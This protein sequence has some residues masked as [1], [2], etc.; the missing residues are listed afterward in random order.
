MRK[1]MMAAAGLALLAGCATGTNGAAT[2]VVAMS[3]AVE[4]A[5]APALASGALSPELAG[6]ARIAV[7]LDMIDAW[8][9]KDW[10]R[11]IDLFAEDGSLH[12]MMIA[13]IVGRD[14]V[15]SR[16]NYMAEGLEQITLTPVNLGIVNDVVV[17]ERV[18]SFTY[19][20]KK[21]SVPVVGIIVVEDGKV[22]EWRE[23]Y[24]RAELLA[25]MGIG[26]DFDA[27][28]R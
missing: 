7:V 4:R 25:A 27:E 24:D 18:D 10:P 15:G 28:A 22:K 9:M 21:G 8:N 23:Y 3:P 11:V 13:P 2:G 1:L 26:T 12:S 16:I 14:S 6:D 19:K 5:S 20:G 17:L